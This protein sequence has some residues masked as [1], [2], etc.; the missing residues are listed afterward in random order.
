MVTGQ[1]EWFGGC[2]RKSCILGFELGISDLNSLN[3][4]EQKL[5]S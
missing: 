2:D 1:W 5:P 3:S 4:E